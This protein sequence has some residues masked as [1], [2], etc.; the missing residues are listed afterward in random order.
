MPAT[1]PA[2]LAFTR[3]VDAAYDLS[4]LV[5]QRLATDLEQWQLIA[6]Q[7]NPAMLEM[8]R[9]RDRQP[10]RDLVQWAGEFVGKY[11][12]AGVLVWR[13]HRD[14]RL[15][16]QLQSV[17]AELISVQDESGYLGPYPRDQ[18]LTGKRIARE[19]IS[20][21]WD[22]WGHYNSMLGLL[23]WYQEVGDE[24]ALAACRRAAD[25][26]CSRFLDAG[27]T[28]SAAGAPCQNLAVIHGFCLL[29]QET[30]EERYL[31]MARAVEQAWQVPPAGD[32]LRLALAGVPFF[33]TPQTHWESLHSVQAILAL[34]EITGDA[35]YRQAF[36]HIWRSLL[37]GD[38][39]NTGGFS[40][41]ESVTGN[42]FDPGVIETCCTVAW[43]ALS[44]DMLRLTGDAR[45]ADELELSTLNATL[46]AQSPTGRWWTYNTPMDGVR[47]AS[48]H[49]IVFQSREGSPE[50]NCC[51][52]NGPRSLGIL[53]E[54][55][56]MR[57]KDGL[58]L[59]YYGPSTFTL[60]LPGGQRVTLVQQTEYPLKG[61]VDIT[62][63][64]EQATV[65]PLSLRIPAWSHRTSVSINGEPVADIIPGEYLLLKR[66]WK[67]GDHIRM[68]LD[69]SLRQ[70]RGEREAEGKASFYRGPLLLAYD[71]RFNQIDPDD[72]Q[73]PDSAAEPEIT[74][75]TG[76]APAPWLL[77]RWRDVAQ[78]ELYLCDFATAGAAGTPYRTW[79]PH[80]QASGRKERSQRQ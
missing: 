50:L 44:V 8:F 10:R 59:N 38:R 11:L 23:L 13:L 49:D 36:E 78:R 60:S 5:G 69:M 47:R 22:V 51:S 41:G 32:Y 66:E 74:A 33:Q 14:Q 63:Q 71:R 1:E 27:E 29:Y 19:R 62:I 28:I 53:S 57:D 12:T 31:R 21:L 35:Q 56:V 65:F 77:L 16:H 55:A 17:V 72:L 80:P 75:W 25:Y 52:V 73:A 37:A 6:P 61:Q 7:A 58:V 24:Q 3:P 39:H 68:E 48:A 79:L 2:R 64:P 70:W 45:I 46:G 9:D 20:D 42:P 34:Y 30:S 4:G 18:R 43:M 67:P 26:I 76:P 54:W 40:S 15:H